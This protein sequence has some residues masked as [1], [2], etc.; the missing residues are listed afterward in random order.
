MAKQMVNDRRVRWGANWVKGI[1]DRSRRM[2]QHFS[3]VW[4]IRILLAA[5]GFF[6]GRAWIVGLLS[7]F[8]LAYYAVVLGSRRTA[9]PLVFLSIL[10]GVATVSEDPHRVFVVLTTLTAYRMVFGWLSRRQRLGSVEVPVAVIGTD[11]LV[12]GLDAAI[13]GGGNPFTWAVVG[14]DAVLAGILSMI[15]L[16]AIPVLSH[17]ARVRPL[18]AEEIL[19]LVILFGSVLTG[20]QGIAVHGVSLDAVLSRY[21][22]LIFAV[23]GG[24]G[25]GAAVGVVTGILMT[26]G[27]MASIYEIGVLAFSGLLA[28]LLQEGKKIGVGLGAMIGSILLTAYS[29]DWHQVSLG[30]QETVAAFLLFALTP[31]AWIDYAARFTPGTRE[32]AGVRQ[33]YVRRA[34]DM[35]AAR[36]R[37]VS[38]VFDEL[39]QAFRGAERSTREPEDLLNEAVERS[40]KMVCAS[41]ARRNV[42]WERDF[43]ATYR[44]MA[45]TI[46]VMDIDGPIQSRDAPDDLRRR[47]IRTE[48]MIPALWQS[49][50]VIHRDAFWNRQIRESRELVG[51]QLEGVSQIMTNLAAEIQR[52]V[53]TASE[54]EEHVLAALE[55]IGLHIQQVDI[56]SLE[57]GKVSIEITQ[58]MCTGHEESA[59]LI[60]PLLSDIVGE[61]ISVE[62]IHC[63]R[64]EGPCTVSFTSSKS[65]AIRAGVASAA[66]GGAILSGDS[67]TLL[68][69][70]NGK[71][72]VAISDGMGNGERAQAESKAAVGMLEQ[73]LKAGFDEQLSVRTVNDVLMLRSKEEMYATLDLA[74]VDLFTART[75]F[76]KIG[77][78][79]SFV[80]RDGD[81]FVIQGRGLPIGILDNLSFD[82]IEETLKPGDLLI[83]VS[84]GVFEAARHTEEREAWLLRQIARIESRDPQEVADLLVEM[85][86]R[87][88]RGEVPDDTTVVV[89]RIDPAEPEWATIHLPGVPKLRRPKRPADGRRVVGVSG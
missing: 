70:G 22:L 82:A 7:P 8:S 47:C 72:A 77:A 26:L 21:L 44:A 27:N 62:R 55:H 11:I 78:V 40:A 85:A 84:D 73:L 28:G 59:K 20:M 38:E 9:A 29:S 65:F 34:R 23:I 2:S 88:N 50:E 3:L 41:C 51:A 81:V 79:P 75:E 14:L 86:V 31:S 43:Y 61:P 36:I 18:R 42:C 25:L 57:E 74:L 4:G 12:K 33:D 69:V 37:E 66:K 54:Q 89:A 15:F 46:A 56:I 67:Y 32:Y 76:L 58:A 1:V 64:G 6:L 49:L 68:D 13:A 35:M 5:I 30:L 17:R 48:R 60:A 52:E 87:M 10:A 16:Q 53:N 80:K 63:S 71:F 83:M 24:S 19:C 39:G 45:D